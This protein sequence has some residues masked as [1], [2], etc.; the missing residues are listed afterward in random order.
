MTANDSE[1]T[2]TL[3]PI[4]TY[5]SLPEKTACPNPKCK[6][7]LYYY[8][9]TQVDDVKAPILL[10]CASCKHA[11]PSPPTAE[12]QTPTERVS[13]TDTHYEVLGVGKTATADEIS[14][15]YRKKS[16]QCHPDRT[17]GREA[18]WERL[19]KAYE[20]L[21]DKRKR[22]WYDIDLEKGTRETT[23]ED[24]TSQGS[25]RRGHYSY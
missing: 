21:G 15:A 19:T 11:F 14:R 1:N 17:I 4:Q 23:T 6:R 7:D 24:P 22:Y 25:L 5:L 2:F 8:P 12:S 10:S 20:V 13:V 9:P 18:E 16:L 3:P